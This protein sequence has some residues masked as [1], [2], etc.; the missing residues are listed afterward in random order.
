LYTGLVYKHLHSQR[1]SKTQSNY[2]TK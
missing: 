1:N 2:K